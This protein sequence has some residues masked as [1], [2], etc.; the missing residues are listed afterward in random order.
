MNENEGN[1]NDGYPQ[2][3]KFLVQMFCNHFFTIGAFFPL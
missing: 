2:K 1:Q 3:F